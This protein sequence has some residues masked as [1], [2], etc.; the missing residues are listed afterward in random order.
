MLGVADPE[1]CAYV[2]GRAQAACKVSKMV[3]REVDR[4][5]QPDPGRAGLLK[6]AIRG[7]ACPIHPTEPLSWYVKILGRG[8]FSKVLR[9]LSMPC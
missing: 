1:P 2:L 3:P 4:I 6:M 5:R 7:L 9:D 8:W